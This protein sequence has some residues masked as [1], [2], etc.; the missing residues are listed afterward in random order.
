LNYGT[1]WHA[2]VDIAGLQE[3]ETMLVLGASGGVGMAAIDIGQALGADVVV[4]SLF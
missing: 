1:A 2:I 4:G 3:G